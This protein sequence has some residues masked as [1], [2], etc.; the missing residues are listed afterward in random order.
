MIIIYKN[1][2]EYNNAD[3]IQNRK[4]D[5][6]AVKLENENTFDINKRNQRTGSKRRKLVNEITL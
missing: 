5:L 4:A 2:E 6:I 3:R 1:R